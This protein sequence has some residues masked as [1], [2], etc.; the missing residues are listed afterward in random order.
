MDTNIKSK[1]GQPY[2]P[3]YI[4]IYIYIYKRLT[5]LATL[6]KQFVCG[7]HNILPRPGRL[8]ILVKEL[9]FATCIM[10]SSSNKLSTSVSNSVKM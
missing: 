10:Q 1:E 8:S 3:I 6:M 9:T 4:Y 7:W 2:T 5:R